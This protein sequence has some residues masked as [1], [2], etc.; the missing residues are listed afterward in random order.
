MKLLLLLFLFILYPLASFAEIDER[1]TDVYFANGILTDEGNAT[2]N[3]RLLREEIISVIYSGNLNKFDKNIGDVAE[4]YN[5]THGWGIGDL[6][7]SLLQKLSLHEVVDG[8][9]GNIYNTLTQNAHSSDLSL[10]VANYKKSIQSGHKVLVVAHS[11]GNLFT[12]EAYRKLDDWMQDYFEAISV[13]SPGHFPIKEGT[14]RVSWDNDLVAHIGLYNDFTTNP[15]RKRIYN[16][17]NEVLD[18]WSDKYHAFTYYMGEEI[19]ETDMGK[20]QKFSTSIGKNLILG[21]ISDA[22]KKLE[23]IPSQWEKSAEIGCTCKD[24]AIFVK[25][26]YDSTLDALMQD[27]YVLPFDEEGKLYA[28]GFDYIKG[29]AEGESV[30]NDFNSE[31]C[32][33]LLPTT[34]VIIGPLAVP[35]AKS[36]VVEV[37]L[38]WDKP[39]IDLDLEVKWDV[40]SVDIKDSGCPKEHF[41]VHNEGKIFPGRYSINVNDKSDDSVKEMTTFPIVVTVDIKRPGADFESYKYKIK[42]KEHLKFVHVADIKVYR[43]DD[44]DK[45]KSGLGF[46]SEASS[47]CPPFVYTPSTIPPILG[48]LGNGRKV[49]FRAY[50]DGIGSWS[51]GAYGGGHSSSADHNPKCSGDTDCIPTPEDGVQGDSKNYQGTWLGLTSV[52]GEQRDLRET[53]CTFPKESCGCLPCEYD[54]ISYLKQ[55]YLGPL[56]NANF[57]IYTYNKFNSR[58]PMYEGKTTGGNSL[59]NAGELNIPKEVSESLL[60]EQLYIIEVSGGEDIDFNDDLTVDLN[61]TANLGKVYAVAT[62]KE[63]NYIGLKINILTTMAYSLIRDDISN[64]MDQSSVLLQLNEIANRLLRQK[65]YP[66]TDGVIDN[67]DLLAWLPT[68][69][70]DILLRGYSPIEDIIQKVFNNEDIFEETH[71]YVY[72]ALD[73]PSVPVIQSFNGHITEDAAKGTV[74]GQLNVLFGEDVVFD[75]LSGKRHEAFA[76]DEDGIITFVSNDLLDYETKW[77]YK[78]HVTAHNKVGVSKESAVYIAVVN[79]VDAPEYSSFEGGIIDENATAGTIAGRIKFD[80]GGAPVQY[81]TLEGSAKDLFDIDINGTIHLLRSDVLDYEKIYTY[82]FVVYAYNSL[83]RS[84]PIF[85][86]INVN[87][88]NDIAQVVDYSGGYAHENALAGSY[89]GKVDF[90]QNVEIDTIALDGFGSDNFMIDTNGTITVADNANFD[91]KTQPYYYLDVITNNMYGESTQRISIEIGNRDNVP[92]YTGFVGGNIAENSDIGTYV[93]T[94]SFN[95]PVS[96]ITKMYISGSE[97]FTVNKQGVISVLKDTLDFEK[98]SQY[99]FSVIASNALGDSLPVNVTIYI[100]DVQE[101]KVTLSEITVDAVDENTSVGSVIGHVNIEDNG[102]S[103]IELMT[104]TGDGH[105]DFRVSKEGTIYVQRAL[106]YERQTSYNLYCKAQNEAG[107][108]D[109][110][111]LTININNLLDEVPVISATLSSLEENA[112]SS[113]IIGEITIIDYGDSA[114]VG[115]SLSGTDAESFVLENNGSLHL[116]DGVVADYEYKKSYELEVFA[117]NLSGI[118]IHELTIQVNNAADV[119]PELQSLSI[120]VFENTVKDSIGQFTLSKVDSFEGQHYTIL[121]ENAHLFRVDD[122]GYIYVDENVS[123]DYESMGSLKTYA[124]TAKYE[125]IVGVSLPVDLNITVLNVDEPAII[126]SVHIAIA[127]GTPATQKLA[128]ITTLKAGDYPIASYDLLSSTFEVTSV[129]ELRVKQGQRLDYEKKSHYALMLSATTSSGQ[130]SKNVDV[131]IDVTNIKDNVVI[132]NLDMFVDENIDTVDPIGKLDVLEYGDEEIR[133]FVLTG[134]DATYFNISNLGEIYFKEGMRPNYEDK[135]SYL[136][137]TYALTDT[138]QSNEVE[139]AISINNVIEINTFSDFEGAIKEDAKA[140]T[141]IGTLLKLIDGDKITSMRL[142]GVDAETFNVDLNGTIYLASNTLNYD[143]KSQYNLKL[144]V[145]NEVNTS[146]YS[147]VIITVNAVNLNF[148]VGIGRWQ[149]A[150]SNLFLIE[151]NGSKTLLYSDISSI[152]ANIS[153]TAKV[154]THHLRLAANKIYLYEVSGGLEVDSNLDGVRDEVS[155]DNNGTLHAYVRGAWLT[156]N[157]NNL[158]INLMTE[159]FYQWVNKEMD[160]FDMASLN[161]SLDE[162]YTPIC[163]QDL[164]GNETQWYNKCSSEDAL[165]YSSVNHD[166]AW[167][168]NYISNNDLHFIRE[169]LL[170]DNEDAINYLKNTFYKTFPPQQHRYAVTNDEKSLYLLKQND[171]L[172]YINLDENLST[173]T[174]AIISGS[175]EKMGLSSD[176]QYMYTLTGECVEGCTYSL[177]IN[178]IQ[179]NTTLYQRSSIN[180]NGQSLLGLTSTAAFLSSGYSLDLVDLQDKDTPLLYMRVFS[181]QLG[182]FTGLKAFDSTHILIANNKGGISYIDI[183]DITNLQLLDNKLFKGHINQI[184]KGLSNKFFTVIENE[185]NTSIGELEIVNNRLVL[186]NKIPIENFSIHYNAVD[187]FTILDDENILIVGNNTLYRYTK[188]VT[189]SNWNITKEESFE[190]YVIGDVSVDVLVNSS[191]IIITNGYKIFIFDLNTFRLLETLD[192]ENLPK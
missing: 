26:K 85:V 77:L 153:K 179:S 78:L 62:G 143:L 192:Y 59:Y 104:L 90:Q 116:A 41:Y 126:E 180:T 167:N 176:S 189:T 53:E 171:E 101:T 70:K 172:L 136:F 188:D 140:G 122:N 33:T 123:I 60:D 132:N 89:V 76:V 184:Y 71:Q 10:Q 145:N 157:D 134:N 4:A 8:I 49:E 156:E 166:Y 84:M 66:D 24:K 137:N 112:N 56:R 18:T 125:N 44:K 105:E 55:I 149:G 162:G 45:K 21:H 124:L 177:N 3:S 144:V 31:V 163:R 22:M 121:G 154:S 191:R 109:S 32:R 1:K 65:V 174:P 178:D 139:I 13:A 48:K 142:V 185:N 36:G 68:V 146:L 106:D 165:Y 129:G 187:G 94:I 100:D 159:A 173:Q 168:F 169:Q 82:G 63:L 46:K 160:G 186:L 158:S 25:H 130:T 43:V 119:I 108:S 12:Y 20:V 181:Y 9:V 6:I 34:Q 37:F 115:L 30:L 151:N 113:Y 38:T 97:L 133:S 29:S 110:Q 5:S 35:Q 50:G 102:S 135:K 170:S 16:S 175:I 7:E 161:S 120:S 42:D 79:I 114:F 73:K 93:A 69:D 99:R 2:A 92:N 87:D 39:A 111:P 14:P 164:S 61:P 40:G 67:S 72:D 128:D 15:Y 88:I 182:E 152:D 75:G 155:V 147:D 58:E 23:D 86:N 83:G 52:A 183:S 91:F 117:E 47:T 11:Q 127:E 131:I 74:V 96:P 54:I 51:S 80:D 118:A 81:L 27:R 150:L 17:V 98:S 141:G 190:N 95:S 57:A 19:S 28:T 103:A 138:N 148:A 107:N 64:G